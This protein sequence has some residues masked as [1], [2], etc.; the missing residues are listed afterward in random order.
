[1]SGGS[2]G[3][4]GP[5]SAGACRRLAGRE[6]RAHEGAQRDAAFFAIADLR[7]AAWFLWMTPLEVAFSS[8][9]A[10]SR[11]SWTAVSLSPSW[12][13]S[14]NL[15]TADFRPVFTALLRS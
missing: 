13:A 9:L 1:M 10:A 11:P 15:R 3:R 8:F 2:R 4:T 14:R 6:P 5:A 12:A 7:F